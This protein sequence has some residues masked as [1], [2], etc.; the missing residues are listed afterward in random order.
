M[1]ERIVLADPNIQGGTPVFAGTR[2]A[3]KNLFDYLAAGETLHS[4]LLDF[5]SVDRTKVL[6][7]LEMAKQALDANAVFLHQAGVTQVG[8]AITE[9]MILE[10]ALAYRPYSLV[11]KRTTC[12]AIPKAVFL[13]IPTQAGIQNMGTCLRVEVRMIVMG[14]EE[15]QWGGARQGWW[16]RL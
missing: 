5:P 9:K 7:T 10:F 4:F 1:Q 6:V 16:V 8:K 14:G 15:T 12:E 3:V 13:V 11:E 2:V